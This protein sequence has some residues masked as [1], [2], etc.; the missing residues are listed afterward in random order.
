MPD[1]YPP[2]SVK[3][4]APKAA[5]WLG[6][7]VALALFLFAARL[8]GAATEAFSPVVELYLDR[9]VTSDP[10]ALGVSWLAAYG[11]LNGSVV[12]AVSVAFFHA[13]LV[14]PTQF[15]LLVAGARLG[16]SG[17]IVLI[18]GL[19]FLQERQGPVMKSVSMGILSFLVTQTIYLPATAVGYITLDWLLSAFPTV[20]LADDSG[21]AKSMNGTATDALVD[22]LGAAPTFLLAVVLLFL[23]LRLFDAV[24]DKVDTEQLRHHFHDKFESRW[25]PFV[26]GLV[27]AGV[28]ASIVFSVGIVVPLYNRDSVDLDDIVPYIMGANISTFVDTVIVGVALGAADALSIVAWFIVVLALVTGL[29]LAFYRPYFTFVETLLTHTVENRVVFFAFFVLLVAVPGLLIFVQ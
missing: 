17:V 11:L 9:I 23:S 5:V 3:D 19:E 20:E 28:T 7:L 18:G 26:L 27:V 6:V 1:S 14:S 12:A 25:F 2:A 16:A 13:E 21:G 29:A 4:L 10:S 24:L 22:Y 8:L 15:F